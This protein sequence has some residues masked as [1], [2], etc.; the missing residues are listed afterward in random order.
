MLRSLLLTACQCMAGPTLACDASS[1]P[2]R[3]L[4]V[5]EAIDWA[6][7]QTLLAPDAAYR[8]PTMV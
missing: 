8:D 7:M 5:I 3:Y 6:T 1:L 2:L 4:R